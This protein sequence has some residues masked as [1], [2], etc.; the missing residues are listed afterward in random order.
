MTEQTNH[1]QQAWDDGDI[2]LIT[3]AIISLLITT[4]IEAIQCSTSN[5]SSVLIQEPTKF[6]TPSSNTTPIESGKVKTQRLSPSTKRPST[7][8]VQ[9]KA[10]GFTSQ[11]IPVSPTA[12]STRS[13]RSKT[14]STTVT[15]TEPGISPTSGS[16]RRSRTTTSTT[17]T[18][19]LSPIPQNV[20]TTADDKHT[21]TADWSE[22]QPTEFV[23]VLP[24]PQEEVQEHT[25]LRTK[26][27]RSK[28]KA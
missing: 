14:S 11:D 17:P 18:T 1:W 13:K 23:S 24:E 5:T 9:K 20:L 3:I 6:G 16:R 2:L 25:V 10:V 28:L 8:G 27:S 7:T 22:H 26:V 4:L 12:S 15:S 19:T 21:D